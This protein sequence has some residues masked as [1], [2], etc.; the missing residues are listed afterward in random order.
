MD[1][2]QAKERD[3]E[4]GNGPCEGDT[5]PKGL[6]FFP[7][8]SNAQLGLNN[9]DIGEK[10]KDEVHSCSNYVDSK[11]LNTVDLIVWIWELDY[12]RMETIRMMEHVDF[13]GG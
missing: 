2:A 6:M 4:N 10:N 12:I 7:W 13:S 1:K 5:S 11:S 8:G 9:Q 3:A